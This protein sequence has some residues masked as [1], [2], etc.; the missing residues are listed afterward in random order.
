MHMGRCLGLLHATEVTYRG[1]VSLF[2]F[3]ALPDSELDSS[4]YNTCTSNF[5]GEC[6]YHSLKISAFPF[7]LEKPKD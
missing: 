5:Q 2:V 1:I 6:L 7:S 4:Q 3:H